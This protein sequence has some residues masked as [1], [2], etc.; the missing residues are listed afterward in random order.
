MPRSSPSRFSSIVLG[1]VGFGATAAGITLVLV[2]SLSGGEHRLLTETFI[3]FAIF[4]A[5]GDLL[6]VP[7]ERSA[8]FSLAL[9]PGIAFVLLGPCPGSKG[10]GTCSTPILAAPRR[11]LVWSPATHRDGFTRGC[12]IPTSHPIHRIVVRYR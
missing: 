11:P 8:V 5:V 7:L 6:E 3:A 12:E 10:A 4:V 9:A 1:T 2:W